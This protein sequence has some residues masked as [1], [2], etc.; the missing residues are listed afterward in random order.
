MAYWQ[1]MSKIQND[2]DNNFNNSSSNNNNNNNNNVWSTRK[3]GKTW[4]LRTDAALGPGSGA[5]GDRGHRF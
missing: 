1:H 5:G 2:D 4:K 3:S